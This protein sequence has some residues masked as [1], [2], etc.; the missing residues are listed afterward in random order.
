MNYR[1]A[2]VTS[3]TKCFIKDPALVSGLTRG[4]VNYPGGHNEGY[5]STFKQC[6][7][8][9]YDAIRDKPEPGAAFYPTF[10]DGH[11]EVVLCDAILQSHQEERWVSV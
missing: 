10:A 5:P 8:A 1:S 7:R 9:F 11:K 3:P 6:F 4:Y 2:I